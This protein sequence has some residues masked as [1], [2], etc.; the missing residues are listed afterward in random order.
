MSTSA[1]LNA[2]RGYRFFVQSADFRTEEKFRE[3]LCQCFGSEK[4]EAAMIR[5]IPWGHEAWLPF[6]RV[7]K[8]RPSRGFVC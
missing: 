4:A 3:W 7:W 6:Q 5:R 1:F 8:Q 2:P